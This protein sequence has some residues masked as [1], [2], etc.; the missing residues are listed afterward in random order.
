M[1]ACRMRTN[2]GPLSSYCTGEYILSI[3]ITLLEIVYNKCH[4]S[5]LLRLQDKNT[6]K[7]VTFFLQEL[8]RDVI[9]R[10]AQLQAPR[11]QEELQQCI[12]AHLLS[13]VNKI[14]ALLEY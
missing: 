11:R 14:Y 13:V 8:K 2:S 12:Q 10:H 9:F 4:Q 6:Q 1:G 5:L 3:I 7:V